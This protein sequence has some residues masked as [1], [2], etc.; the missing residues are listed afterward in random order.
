MMAKIY[1]ELDIY[2]WICSYHNALPSLWE[3]ALA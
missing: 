2:L 1:E 3:E